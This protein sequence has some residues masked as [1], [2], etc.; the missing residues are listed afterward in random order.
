MRKLWIC[1][2]IDGNIREKYRNLTSGADSNHNGMRYHWDKIE[3]KTWIWMSRFG[4]KYRNLMSESDSK[5][6]AMREKLR[7]NIERVKEEAE[8]S[9]EKW[10]IGQWKKTQL[11]RY[12]KNFEIWRA[13]RRST[14]IRETIF[15]C[16]QIWVEIDGA[17]HRREVN[18]EHRGYTNK[19]NRSG[20]NGKRHDFNPVGSIRLKI[21]ILKFQI[22]SVS[23]LEDRS[24]ISIK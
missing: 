24:K 5:H 6:D 21:Y 22:S 8:K 3:E 1:G 2:W 11:G 10:W 23:L 12:G 4:E 9:I 17:E 19:N 16:W 20:K 15:H 13:D 18:E 7:W 14:E